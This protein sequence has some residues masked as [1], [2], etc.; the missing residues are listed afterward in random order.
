MAYQASGFDLA[1]SFTSISS[2]DVISVL[3][4]GLRGT[5]ALFIGTVFSFIFHREAGKWGGGLIET[6]IQDVVGSF[7]MVVL[8]Y[9]LLHGLTN[10]DPTDVC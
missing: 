2:A 10:V 4:A 8:Y 9:R 1:F 7:V 6:A 5:M 3:T